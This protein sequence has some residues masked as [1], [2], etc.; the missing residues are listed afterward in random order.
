[1]QQSGKTGFY[2]R[3]LAAGVVRSGDP[4]T[5]LQSPYPEATI[6]RLNR[7]RYGRP[8][9]GERARSAECPALAEVWR[10]WLRLHDGA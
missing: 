4:I 6:L 1:M 7:L 2:A 9:P 10:R 5:L 3:V 8:Q